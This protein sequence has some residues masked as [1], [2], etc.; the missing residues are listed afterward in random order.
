MG[1]GLTGQIGEKHRDGVS[2]MGRAAA[3]D[4]DG[5]ALDAFGA[6]GHLEADRHFGPG[7]ERR[8]AAEFEAALA[9]ADGIGRQIET[10]GLGGRTKQRMG[11]NFSCAHRIR[12][13]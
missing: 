4:D 13:G 9:N 2:C 1:L 12:L 11:I 5:I 8:D 6:A 10:L 3:S 7:R